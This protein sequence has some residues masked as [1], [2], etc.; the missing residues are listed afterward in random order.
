MSIL[1]F[2]F[3]VSTGR[4][5][6]MR[7][8]GFSWR[9]KHCSTPPS[10]SW[11]RAIQRLRTLRFLAVATRVPEKGVNTTCD[12]S[13]WP[14]ELNCDLQPFLSCDSTLSNLF[15]APTLTSTLRRGCRFGCDP[16][17]VS[18]IVQWGFLIVSQV[19]SWHFFLFLFVLF[20]FFFITLGLKRCLTAK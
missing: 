11:H 15:P 10:P 14:P 3:S 19:S 20:F 5:W 17:L 4:K 12:D 13:M 1:S 6:R 2:C 7:T 8:F 16:L 18:I 9:E